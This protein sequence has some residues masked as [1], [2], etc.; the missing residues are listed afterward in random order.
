MKK[1]ITKKTAMRIVKLLQDQVVLDNH[2]N[3]TLAAWVIQIVEQDR[4]SGL[5]LTKGLAT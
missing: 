2:S 1:I 3:A 5:D 4:P